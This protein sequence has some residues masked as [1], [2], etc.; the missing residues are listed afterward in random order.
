DF[1]RDRLDHHAQITA[2]DL[3]ALE[4]LIHHRAR[5]VGRHGEAHALIAARARKDRRV[6][7]DQLAARVDERA[8]R[9]AGV[10]R[11]VGLDEVFVVFNAQVAAPRRADDAHRNRLADTEGIADGKDDVAYL[12]LR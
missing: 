1:R 11:S 9:I 10:D 7:A 4:Q 2:H 8:S 3:T 12:R 5:Q 6:D